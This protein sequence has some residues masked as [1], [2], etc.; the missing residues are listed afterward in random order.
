MQELAYKTNTVIFIIPIYSG[1][2]LLSLVLLNIHV[3]VINIVI[4]IIFAIFGFFLH[5]FMDLAIVWMAFWMTDVWC[6][7]H[8]KRI[9]F[10][11][12]GGRRFP[13]DLL[14][15]S[16]RTVAEF[17]PFKFFYFVPISYFVGTRSSEFILK[18]ILSLICWSLVFIAISIFLWR[19][20]IKK[21][22]AYGN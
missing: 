12:L 13:L 17:L 11:I 1:A 7:E 15:A 20:G 6:F 21:Y 14:S 18:D 5:Y 16:L 4:G 8:V 19:K 22:E 10:N 9:A 3:D 2:I